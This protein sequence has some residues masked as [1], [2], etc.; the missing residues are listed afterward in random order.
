MKS[1]QTNPAQNGNQKQGNL[2]AEKAKSGAAQGLRDLFLDELQDIYWAEKELTIAIP[3][4]IKNATADELVKALT[5]HLE[6]TKEQVMRLEVVFA[7]IGEKVET[8]KCEAMEGLLKEAEKI[9][10]E[11]EIGMVRDA[12]IIL[13]GQKIEHYEI[14]T[15]GTLCAFAKT[16]REDNAAALLQVTLDEEKDADEMLSNIAESFI[17]FQA[18]GTEEEDTEVDDTDTI[19]SRNAKREQFK[20]L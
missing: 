1:T 14:A 7:A 6:V 19:V 9:M 10:Q 15:Y 8:K 2:I 13:A 16:L 5:E 17:N 3:K 12:G 20:S 11:T 18:V 4:M